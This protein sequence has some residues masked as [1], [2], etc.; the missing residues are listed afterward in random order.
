MKFY[1]LWSLHPGNLVGEYATEADAL[2]DAR[3][4][5]AAGWSADDLS[6]GWGDTDDDEQGGQIV[7]GSEL[8]ARV[9][10]ADSERSRRSA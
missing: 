8:A 3:N 5:L 1:D 7:N 2:A 4:L 6:L 9:L 10:A